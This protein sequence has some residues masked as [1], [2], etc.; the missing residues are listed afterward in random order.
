[1]TARLSMRSRAVA[2][3]A[4]SALALGVL[5]GCGSDDEKDAPAAGSSTLKV[6]YISGA[7]LAPAFV[8]DALGCFQK[9]GLTVEYTPIKN[10]ADAIAFLSTDK[11]DAYVGSPSAGMFNQVAKG[12]ELKMVASLGSVNTPEGE[13][14]PSGLFGGKS[15]A[16]VEDLKGKRV[17]VLGTVG[18]ATSY[19][20]GKSLEAGGLTFDDVEL[21]SL[22]LPD[23][24]P[25]LKNGGIEGA[26]LIAPETQKALEQDVAHALVDSKK[27]YGTSTTSGIMYGPRL[28]KEDRASGVKFIRATACATNQMLG[29]WRKDAKVVSALATF[30]KVPDET[31]SKGGLYVFDP[32]LTV[33]T[34]TLTEMQEMFMKV[35]GT[36]TYDEIIPADKLVDDAIR[37]E[38]VGKAG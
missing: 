23:M 17:G 4:L 21:V 35:K 19:L 18:T 28:L 30:M 14:A 11:L 34:G 37:A 15:V 36:L 5:A 13:A 8:A 29:D 3:F 38:A 31:I 25:A 12:A 2:A 9:E 7:S 20:L 27:A 6:G 10:P 32:T 22:A 1:M 24:V 33:N 16:K 26:L